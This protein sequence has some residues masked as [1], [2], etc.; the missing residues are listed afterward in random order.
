MANEKILEELLKHG[1]EDSHLNITDRTLPFA[2]GVFAEA[3]CRGDYVASAIVQ[4][5]TNP[6]RY[7]GLIK[8]PTLPTR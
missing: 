5:E 1:F 4:T 6:P 7:I 2:S 3:L 8:K